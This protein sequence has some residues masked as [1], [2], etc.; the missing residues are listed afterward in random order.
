MDRPAAV[1]GM[2]YPGDAKDLRAEVERLIG[3][4][5]SEEHAIAVVAPHAGY[6]YSGAVAG[7]VYREVRV[8]TAAIVLCPNHTGD[9]ARAAIMSSGSW[10]IPGRSVPVD[11]RLAEEL[12][13]AAGLTED[14]LA[15]AREH[16][17]EVQL[18]FLM[19]RNPSV[20]LVPVCLAQ[21]PFESCARIGNAL[22]DVVSRHGRDLL[23]VA[24]TDMS[25]YLS[26]DAAREKD[27]LAMDR[28]AAL[29][30]EGLYSTVLE[31][32]I[33]MCG[34]IATVVVLVASKALGATTA[35]L[36]RYANSGDVSG[37]TAHVV[38]YAGFV[39]R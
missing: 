12:R 39:I 31:R 6:A 14:R 33:S 26:A 37:D 11:K 29:D 34:F 3:P 30:P 19:Y 36:V 1:A 32:D 9:G 28:I 16:S 22:A 8:P 25:H 15:H 4:A 13:D 5:P 18:P 7:A 10:H 24:S 2:F 27:Q 20:R 17:L 23:L 21:L 35:R 38:G